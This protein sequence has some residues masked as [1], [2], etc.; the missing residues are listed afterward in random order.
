MKRAIEIPDIL[1]TSPSVLGVGIDVCN[2]HRLPALLN[3]YGDRFLRRV[4]HPN[5][6]A[7]IRKLAYEDSSK[8]GQYLASRW[9]VKEACHKALSSRSLRLLFPSIEVVPS[10]G[11]PTIHFM[12]DAVENLAKAG[13]GV[14][15]Q[16]AGLIG[17]STHVSIS[18]D[19]GI[20][21]AIVVI[22]SRGQL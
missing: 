15:T 1:K 10:I 6:I 13:L 4:Y 19:D 16:Q 2:T 20:A 17:I 11:A 7:A 5:E 8:L 12:P 14:D 3:H 22:E 21:A 9:A 18:H